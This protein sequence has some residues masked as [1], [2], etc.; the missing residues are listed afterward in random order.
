MILS[1]L[2]KSIWSY[3][4]KHFESWRLAN[5]LWRNV[6]SLI[7]KSILHKT[8]LNYDDLRTLEPSHGSVTWVTS[9]QLRFDVLQSRDAHDSKKK[10]L[11]SPSIKRRH[12]HKLLVPP[13]TT[14]CKLSLMPGWLWTWNQ[15]KF[16]SSSHNSLVIGCQ[17]V[18]RH[19]S[20]C[21]K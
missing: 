3:K 5:W 15:A 10:I 2:W 21:E 13:R 16:P 11:H 18:S 19:D 4:K 8:Q 14:T 6:V 9:S 20:C 12:L 7:P 17:L 1:K